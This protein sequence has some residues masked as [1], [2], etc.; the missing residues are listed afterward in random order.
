MLKQIGKFTLI[1]RVGRGAYSHVYRAEDPQGRSFA[2]KISTTPSAPYHLAEFQKDLVA[3]ASV[4]HP[5]LVSVQDLGFDDS[6]PYVLMEFVEG[7]DLSQIIKNHASVPLGERVN[8]MQQVAGALKSAHER[9]VFHLDVRPT[10]IMVTDNGAAKL[11]DLGLGRLSY[12]PERLT[13]HG[14]LIG[15]PFYMS[16]ERLSDTGTADAQCDIWSFGVTLYEL[17]CGRHPF[18]HEDGDE[19]IGRIMLDQPADLTDAPPSLNQLVLRTLEKEPGK[20]YRSF[21][22]LLADLKPITVG[23]YR[24]KSD[25]LFAE[26]L[27][28]NIRGTGRQTRH[29]ERQESEADSQQPAAEQL[30]GIS[31]Q[32]PE[33]AADIAYAAKPQAVAEGSQPVA[34]APTMPTPAPTPVVGPTAAI[35]DADEATSLTI[36]GSGLALDTA[37]PAPPR[38]PKPQRPERTASKIPRIGRSQRASP[39]IANGGAPAKPDSGL[40]QPAAS[41]VNAPNGNQPHGHAISAAVPPLSEPPLA[42]PAFDESQTYVEPPRFSTGGRKTSLQPAGHVGETPEEGRAW[43]KIALA[44]AV[45]LL[46]AG[47]LF[48]FWGLYANFGK[49]PAT[50]EAKTITR[51]GRVIK[52]G[53]ASD[54]RIQIPGDKSEV[55]VTMPPGDEAAPKLFDPKSLNVSKVTPATPLN[56]VALLTPPPSRLSSPVAEYSGLPFLPEAPPYVAPLTKVVPAPTPVSVPLAATKTNAPSP[57]SDPAP[58]H[59]VRRG[60]SYKQPVLIH[61][62]DPVYPASAAEQKAQGV[63]SFQATI[64]KDGAVTNLKLMSGDPLL[65]HAAQQAVSQWKFRPAVLNGEPVEVTQTIVVKFNLAPIP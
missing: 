14:Y 2:I 63:V 38:V 37:E 29:P 19:V 24:E 48:Y 45:L 47:A 13:E 46:I 54:D 6:L 57:A 27:K 9:G 15:S 62:V 43:T 49:Q 8:V 36:G 35:A 44:V 11:L 26:A 3:A 28:Q 25:A 56:Q 51:P 5:S 52:P 32:E 7:R 20:R 65:S 4:V 18:Y 64:T 30:I 10:K 42:G 16:P 1:E 61:K 21:A 41:P 12:D 40:S 53:E 33:Y 50:A 17:I 23:L 39:P 31:N 22:E 60:G 55:S 58:V 59:A 34:A